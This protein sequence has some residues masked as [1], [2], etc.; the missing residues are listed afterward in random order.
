MT[1]T[2]DRAWIPRR[3]FRR[4]GACSLLTLAALVG[5]CSALQP[6]AVEPPRLHVL[7]ARAPAAPA[8][9]QRDLVVEVSPPRARPGFDTP[10][11]AYVRK[12]HAIEYYANNRWAEAPAR[13]LGPLL[14]QALEETGAFRAVVQPPAAVPVDLR[15][16][17]ELNR[18]QQNFEA[19]PSRVE[20]AVHV[21]LL[22]VRSRRVLATRTFE[23][24]EDAASDDAY[25]GVVAANRA[26]ARVLAQVSAFTVAESS[27]IR[28][29]AAAS[30]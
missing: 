25:G 11:I 4:A 29:G 8:A 27:A 3:P 24:T 5:A 18:V 15:L 10:E 2:T 22:D 6:A 12:P 14:A 23:A 9:Q 17:T 21:Q 1:A 19:R 16:V 30:P 13:M 26:V 20:V 7:D 28:P